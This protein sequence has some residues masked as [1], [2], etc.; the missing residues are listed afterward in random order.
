MASKRRKFDPVTESTWERLRSAGHAPIAGKPH[1]AERMDQNPAFMG[2][3]VNTVPAPSAV[4]VP[5]KLAPDQISSEASSFD[6]ICIVLRID[7]TLPLQAD[8]SQLGKM[9][10]EVVRMVS[11]IGDVLRIAVDPDGIDIEIDPDDV[12][13]KD[14]A[15]KRNAIRARLQVML[16][17]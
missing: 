4:M 13:M 9:V 17:A 2:R 5:M 7:L 15:R 16:A 14:L 3:E 1:G 11:A 12:T 10:S 8:P 6:G